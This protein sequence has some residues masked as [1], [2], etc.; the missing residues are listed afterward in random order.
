MFTILVVDDSLTQ[1]AVL[2]D[3]LAD[4][5]YGVETAC[6][7][8]EAITRV[9]HS[10]PD[11]ILSDVMMPELNGYHL[12][13]LLKND[14]GTAHIP[15][16]LL[17]NLRERHDRFWGEKAG[18]D[19]YLEKGKDLAPILEAVDTL[20]PDKPRAK[21]PGAPSPQ[22]GVTAEDIQ[23][24]IT[25]IL[26]RLLYDS[27][28]SNEILKLTGLA[29]DVEL[30][31]REFLGF[32]SVISDFS[33]A[34]LLLREGRDKYLLCLR[35][36]E[37][38]PEDFVEQCKK[39]ILA[40]AGLSDLNQS[41]IRFIRFRD[42]QPAPSR[43]EGGFRILF[44][45]PVI[46]HNELLASVSL[47]DTR[48]RRLGEGTRHALDVATQRFLI[49]SRYLRKFKEI[50]EVKADFVSML[51]HDMRSP[52][53]SIKGFTD[54]LAEGIL[55]SVTEDQKGAFR[56]IQSGSDRLLMLI[57]DIL[58]LSKLEAGKMKI[59]V[60]PLQILPLAERAITD[61]SALFKEKD[62]VVCIDVPEELPYVSADGKQLA[63]V[64]TNLLTNAA[65]FTSQGGRITLHAAEPSACPT[66][67][68]DSCLQVSVTDNGPGIPADQQGKLFGRY[69]QLAS[70]TMF[71]KGTGLGLAICKEIIGLHG[72]EIW[73]ES[74]L[75]DEGG[76]RFAFT[77]PLA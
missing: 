14:P 59:D 63:R 7:G 4:K 3:A 53:T 46:D 6:N 13:R 61:L 21:D 27:T 11:L 50:E 76:S 32:L 29:H 56:N 41:R 15:V 60:I 24:R 19:R 40:R 45:Q 2:K 16:I 51:V 36:I 28:I 37:D 57:E 68:L 47:F 69:Q 1:L 33:A 5:G 55:G 20:L 17:T 71:R 12:C 9:C 70:A 18:A 34:G 73:V 75:T 31:A 64:L 38:V 74:P 44:N 23:S 66:E 42:E 25:A 52:L 48:P 26:D 39:E 58:D 22:R 43:T 54:V 10:P 49:V 62:M 8:M 30:L 77:L 72:G 65:K 35:I 67:A